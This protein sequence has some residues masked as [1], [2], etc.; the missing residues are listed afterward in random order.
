MW[1]LV[2]SDLST[3]AE[4]YVNYTVKSNQKG[5]GLVAGL[6]EKW[7]D[8]KL[9]WKKTWFVSHIGQILINVQLFFW[10]FEILSVSFDVVFSAEG[11]LWSLICVT[12]QAPSPWLYTSHSS[13]EDY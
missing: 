7:A 13:A 1:C 10:C 5:L 6:E 2:W 11:L 8:L 4:V 12:S 3:S 9:T